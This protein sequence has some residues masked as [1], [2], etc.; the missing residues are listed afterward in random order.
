MM[1]SFWLIMTV[2]CIHQML[3]QGQNLIESSTLKEVQ[4]G[5]WSQEKENTSDG[6]RA[7]S[8]LEFI[9]WRQGHPT[10]QGPMEVRNL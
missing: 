4:R 7:L 2:S 10:F 6:G 1:A 3:N 8:S 5:L 9:G